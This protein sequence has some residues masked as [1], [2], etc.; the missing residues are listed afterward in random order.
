MADLQRVWVVLLSDLLLICVYDPDEEVYV[1]IE[2]VV[3]LRD[4]S[5]SYEAIRPDGTP[6]LTWMV[7]VAD[8]KDFGPRRYT[9]EADTA[10]LAAMWKCCL[11]RQID[12][13]K[14]NKT[15]PASFSSVSFLF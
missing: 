9:F 10:E 12:L 7:N 13:T 6:D 2:E 4:C 1:V 15:K 5:L 14:Q 11:S 3:Q 8:Q